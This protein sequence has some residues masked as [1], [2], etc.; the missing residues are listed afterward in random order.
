MVFP[1]ETPEAGVGDGGG[2]G[3][4]SVGVHGSASGGSTYTP[5]ILRMP[6]AY[7]AVPEFD[8]ATH[9]ALRHAEEAVRAEGECIVQGLGLAGW[10]CGWVGSGEQPDGAGTVGG[11]CSILPRRVRAYT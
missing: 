3:A 4:G 2:D 11:L 9:T 8:A 10:V 5:V 6:V 1:G 7:P